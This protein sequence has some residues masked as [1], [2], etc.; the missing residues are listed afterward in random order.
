VAALWWEAQWQRSAGGGI[1]NQQSTK[2]SDCNSNENGEYDSDDYDNEMKDNYGNL[3]LPTPPPP[4]TPRSHQAAASVTKLAAAAKVVAAYTTAATNA[5]LLPV[6]AYM[7][8]PCFR[9]SSPLFQ[10]SSLSLLSLCFRCRCHRC[11]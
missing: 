1:N 8:L 10:L 3:P 6:A 5:M 11:F 9:C 7:L 4:P 2:S